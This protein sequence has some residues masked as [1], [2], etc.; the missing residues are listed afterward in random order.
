MY[1][2]YLL[3]TLAVIMFCIPLYNCS[4]MESIHEE[5]LQGEKVYAGKLDSLQ[6]FSGY[7]RVKIVGLT[8]YLGN[9]TECVVSWEDQTKTFQIDKSLTD[10][11]FEMIIENL[12]ERNYE[13]EVLTKD[14]AGNQSVV[15]H[16]KGKAIGD[17]FKDSQMSRRIQEFTFKGAYYSAEWADKA[18]SEFVIKTLFSYKN[19]LDTYTQV[20]VLP[21]D[22]LTN[23]K[24]WKPG[25]DFKI[26][27]AIVTGSTGFDTIYL[28][29]VE[30]F[31][32]STG[33]FQ[34]DK[35]YFKKVHLQ[36]DIHGNAYGGVF[37]GIWDGIK[38]SDQGS[39][40]HSADREGVPHTIT[41]DL[42]VIA[43]L[44]EVELTGR[45]NYHNWNPR[46]IQLWGC[47]T[48]AGKETDLNASDPGWENESIT[49]GWR[50]LIESELPDRVENVIR[51]NTN[52]TKNIR[53]IRY[54]VLEVF[55]PP[56]VGTG[57][58]GCIQEITIWGENIQPAT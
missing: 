23:L 30:G 11:K 51:F 41:F 5:Y 47:E 53:Y 21:D 45:G 48:L 25:G 42:G 54:R 7:K 1:L 58:Y 49:K 38:G 27:S 36:N 24:N 32:P 10:D 2:R 33:V 39:R 18:E 57:A 9:S 19:N 34:L 16:C 50:L 37:E 12:E 13:F 44:T 8:R 28:D 14:R 35:S 29:P 3:K 31:L 15:Q 4:K 6:V 40:Y 55:G 22:K 17:I 20:L 43:D 46:K 26:V 52:D 56:S